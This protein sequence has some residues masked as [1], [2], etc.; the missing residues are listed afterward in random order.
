VNQAGSAVAGTSQT[1]TPVFQ[2]QPSASLTVGGNPGPN[3]TLVWQ[4]DSSAVGG[5]VVLVA[6]LDPGAIDLGSVGMTGI[7]LLL[8][9]Y[10]VIAD[11]PGFLTIPGNPADVTAAPC[12]TFTFSVPAGLPPGLTI[13]NQGIVIPPPIPLPTSGLLPPPPPPNFWFHFTN[14]AVLNT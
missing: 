3:G 9:R 12:G 10:Y 14:V 4:I 5:Q 6:S 7:Q 11:A 2:I 8:D 1:Y 13:Y